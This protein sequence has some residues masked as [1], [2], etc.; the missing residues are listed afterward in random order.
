MSRQLEKQQSVCFLWLFRWTI[1]TVVIINVAINNLDGHILLNDY[2]TTTPSTSSVFFVEGR[3]NFPE[4]GDIPKIATIASQ[5]FS[6]FNG[7]KEKQP[8]HE[9]RGRLRQQQQIS[10]LLDLSDT[11]RFGDDE[12][13]DV[14]TS[15]SSSTSTKSPATMKPRRPFLSVSRRLS[16]RSSLSQHPVNRTTK[17][18]AITAPTSIASTAETSSRKKGRLYNKHSASAVFDNIKE[19]FRG[20]AA[21]A[22]ENAVKTM[23]AR[24]M[25]TFK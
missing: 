14:F 21:V 1:L 5:R 10:S 3:P 15:S 25:E 7:K 16:L 18:E 24:R 2:S 22:A 8:R 13:F 11:S 4:C 23:T 12:S 17:K 6:L 20:G 9:G 19:D